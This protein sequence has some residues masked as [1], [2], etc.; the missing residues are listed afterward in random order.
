MAGQNA[1]LNVVPTVTMLG[2]MKARLVGATRGHALLKKKSDALTVQFRALLKKIVTA[3]ESMGDMMKTSSFA[4]TEVKYVAGENVKHVVLE[5]VKEATLKT[6]FLTLDEAIKTTN[7]R[8]NAL[9]NVVKPKIENTISYIKG[10]LDELE[11]E[12]FF[13]LKKI[14]GYKRREVE[15]QAAN[16][17]AFAEEMV[18]E[19]IS[20]QRGISINAARSLLVGGGE[21]DADIIF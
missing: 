9:E 21:K 1:R 4:L 12:D 13:R 8:V 11:R 15:R 19:G 2:V 16:T 6:S 3:K 5:N 10:E 20:M 14:Q 17:K 7:R 18:L